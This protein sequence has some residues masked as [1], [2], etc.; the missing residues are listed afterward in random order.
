MITTESTSTSPTSAIDDSADAVIRNHALMAAGGGL[1]PLPGLD[2]AAVMGLQINMIKE[3]SALYDVPFRVADV[4]TIL[5]CVIT[6]GLA[7][8]IGQVVNTYTTLFDGLGTFSDN[9][10]NGLVAGAVTFGTGEIIQQHFRQGGTIDNLNYIHFIDYYRIKIQEE[11]LIP[12]D[13]LQIE[14]SI[15]SVLAALDTG[16]ITSQQNTT[17][18]GR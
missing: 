4:R 17:P 11:D 6:T 14:N 16:S 15:R 8:L 10:T 5:S 12:K 9:L 2:T 13:I 18:H 7:K 1:I 3:L